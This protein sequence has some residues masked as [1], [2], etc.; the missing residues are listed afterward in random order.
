ME[1]E[2]WQGL[3][4]ATREYLIYNALTCQ[5]GINRRLRRLEFITIAL[6]VLVAGSNAIFLF[7]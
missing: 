1:F 2:Q 5:S 3:D 4:H 7:P 6:A